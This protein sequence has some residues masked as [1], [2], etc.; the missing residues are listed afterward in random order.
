MGVAVPTCPF[1]ANVSLLGAVGFLL[2]DQI[3]QIA[4]V[5]VDLGVFQVTIQ[6]T[7]CELV[8]TLGLEDAAGQ[9]GRGLDALALDVDLLVA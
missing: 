3:R 1:Y 9:P 7:K 2:T 6:H 8:K 4:H 5:E